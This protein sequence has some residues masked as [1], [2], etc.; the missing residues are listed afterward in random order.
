MKA[1]P[2]KKR[3]KDTPPKKSKGG[4]RKPNMRKSLKRGESLLR[5]IVKKFTELLGGSIKAVSEPGKGS[6]FTVEIPVSAKV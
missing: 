5:A 2:Y 1:A 6:T 4:P 3:R